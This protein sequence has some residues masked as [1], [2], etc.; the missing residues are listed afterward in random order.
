MVVVN[1]SPLCHFVSRVHH[2]LALCGY[3]GLLD[4]YIGHAMPFCTFET[5][6][7]THTFLVT[8]SVIFW[9]LIVVFLNYPINGVL[10]M[11]M[12]MH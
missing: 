1:D 4:L 10:I 6:T 11:M 7:H 5:Y 3:V 9:C 12:I 8:C 2:I